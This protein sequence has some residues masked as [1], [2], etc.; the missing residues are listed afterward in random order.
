MEVVEA[1]AARLVPWFFVVSLTVTV[2]PGAAEEADA[3]A[4]ETMRSGSLV[5][6]CFALMV[7]ELV[8]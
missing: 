5:G 7:T 3:A 1:A 8:P 2:A 4:L 6:S